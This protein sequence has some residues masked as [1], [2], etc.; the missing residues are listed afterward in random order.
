[1]SETTIAV[2]DQPAGRAGT[3]DGG[4]PGLPARARA[5]LRVAR[6]LGSGVRR[7]VAIAAF[8]ALWQVAPTVG[9]VDRAFLSPLSEVLDTWWGLAVDGD[10]WT[11]IWAS[12]HR[13]LAGFAIAISI[14]VPLGLLIAWY[15]AVAG[16]LSPLL[17][18]FL[19]TAAVALLP[20]FTLILGIGDT[21]KI[22]IIA[23]AC[24]WP[25][26]YNTISGARDVDPLLI[27]SARS[28]G[29]PH[30]KLFAKVIVPAALPTIFTGIRLAGAASMLVL[31]TTEYVGAKAGLGYMIISAQFN[32]QIPEMYAGILTVSIIGVAFN[33]L[34]LFIESKVLRWRA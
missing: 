21:S 16:V 28:L 5:S 4:A 25:V 11:N 10:L 2:I 15:R 13:S 6:L 27:K 30:I 17:A 22:A 23:Y 34:L 33:Y 1:M 29:L 8:L 14:A 12:L 3:P 19:N 7:I 31:I 18:I 20:V 24:F 26:L 32:F 9:W